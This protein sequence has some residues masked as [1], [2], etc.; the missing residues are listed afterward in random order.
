MAIHNNVI[1]PDEFIGF[2][3]V[4][5][6]KVQVFFRPDYS[7]L[8]VYAED[9]L[10]YCQKTITSYG[11]TLADIGIPIVIIAESP[12][13]NEF[14]DTPLQVFNSSEIYSRPTNGSSQGTAGF[15]IKTLLSDVLSNTEVITDN[16]WHPIIIVNACQYQ[17]SAG[18]PTETGLRDKN[19]LTLFWGN[20]SRFNATSL[21]HRLSLYIPCKTIVACTRGGK[22]FIRK[23][24]LKNKKQV[25][26]SIHE[27]SLRGCI[28]LALM[29]NKIPFVSVGHPCSWHNPKC[30]HKREVAALKRLRKIP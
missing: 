4:Q 19:F 23:W 13:T 28:E 17:C 10:L 25:F 30:R 27:F 5:N 18:R 12:H 2:A 29:Q 11:K 22:S 8:L 3:F 20:I 7:T 9:S 1:C 21:I 24:L 14:F 16:V 15:F 6:N 26:I